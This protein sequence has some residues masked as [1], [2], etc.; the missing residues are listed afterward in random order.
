MMRMTEPVPPDDPTPLRERASVVRIMVVPGPRGSLCERVVRIRHPAR[1][2]LLIGLGAAVTLAA[3]VAGVVSIVVV[4]SPVARVSAPAH[5]G[6][7]PISGPGPD[8]PVEAVYRAP[9][10]CVRVIV[11]AGDPTYARA[12][13]DRAGSCWRDAA[14]ATTILHKIRGVWRSVMLEGSGFCSARSLP[15]VVRA[16]LGVCPPAA[17][18]P[19]R[20]G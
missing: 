9:F 13:V 6:A 11:A 10:R 3:A 8:D 14:W 12:E 16:E 7:A 17:S 1:R 5:A 4:G 15:A 18:R 2:P 20:L 19:R